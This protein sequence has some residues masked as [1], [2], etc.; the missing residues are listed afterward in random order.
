M[1]GVN[2]IAGP[3][4]VRIEPG[5]LERLGLY[6]AREGWHD[7]AVFVSA[8]MEPSILEVAARGL[9]TAT[10]VAFLA[11]KPDVAVPTSLS[12]DGFAR[13]GAG[14]TVDG[15][16]RSLSSALPD[17]VVVDTEVCRQAPLPLWHSGVGDL[18]AKIT[19]VHD[20]KL[21]FHARGTPST[22]WRPCCRMRP[23]TVHRHPHRHPHPRLLDEDE[24]LTGCYRA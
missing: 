11:D 6:L 5:A 23:C 15:H 1:R 20:W 10:D 18:V 7:P 14:L 13:P 12:N 19:A 2:R 3:T 8:G 22:T 9:D 21:A 16:R 4:L 17:G 24:T